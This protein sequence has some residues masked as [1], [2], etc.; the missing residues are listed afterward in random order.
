MRSLVVVVVG[1]AGGPHT[2]VLHGESGSRECRDVPH[3]VRWRHL[4]YVH[5]DPVQILESTHDLEGD[6]RA[7]PA[8]HRRPRARGKRW[9]EAIDVEGQVGLVIADGSLDGGNGVIHAIAVDAGGIQDH[10]RELIWLVVS[11][12]AN[13]DGSL[14]RHDAFVDRRPEHRAVVD[15]AALFFGVGAVK[16]AYDLTN[17]NFS[18]TALMGFLGGTLIW[19]VGLLADQIAR[20]GLRGGGN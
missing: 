2:Q 5:A 13:L 4:D 7:E 16:F 10:E 15:L 9:I 8:D 12:N 17:G 19:G 3:V 18:E 1:H 6:R 14:G 20:Q 11:A